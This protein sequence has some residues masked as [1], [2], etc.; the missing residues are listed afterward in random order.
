MSHD[1]TEAIDVADQYPDVVQ[2]LT[3]LLGKAAWECEDD[4]CTTDTYHGKQNCCDSLKAYGTFGPWA[5]LG[6]GPTP[7]PNNA[8][9]YQLKT[10]TSLCLAYAK[11]K[12]GKGGTTTP[13]YTKGVTTFGPIILDSW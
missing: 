7:F 8:V 11:E 6:P 5:P 10:N 13:L 1:Q 4:L 9:Q 3:T 12:V 2:S